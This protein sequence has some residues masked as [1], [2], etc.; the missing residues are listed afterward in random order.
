M[1]RLLFYG[2]NHKI[3]T[4]GNLRKVSKVPAHARTHGFLGPCGVAEGSWVP[5]PHALA[6]RV[7]ISHQRPDLRGGT[8]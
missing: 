1:F 2:S 6:R 4:L 3:T 8:P 7:T 5:L